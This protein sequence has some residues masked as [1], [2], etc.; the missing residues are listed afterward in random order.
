MGLIR[1][2][3]RPSIAWLASLAILVS[4]G[5]THSVPAADP[6]SAPSPA[7]L[8]F[9]PI[10]D[11]PTSEISAL[12]VHYREK[13]G[14]ESQVLPPM[15]LQPVDVDVARRQVIAENVIDSM[16]R[17]LPQYAN[18]SA[19]L[20]GITR[21]DMFLRGVNWQFCFGS[22]RPDKRIGV[23]STAR[24]GLHYPGEPPTEATVS[25]RLQKMVTK[26][27]GVMYYGMRL[28]AN[29][30]SVLYNNILGLQELDQ[31]REEF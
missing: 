21:Q 11:A 27:V 24:M 8:L 28:N 5:S 12:V 31:V 29:P 14:I 22:R 9:V 30:R 2:S 26:Y 10:G 7:K 17:A 3:H 6:R 18:T 20:I 1:N 13:F 15:A 16:L 19:V 23:I 4:C 25:R